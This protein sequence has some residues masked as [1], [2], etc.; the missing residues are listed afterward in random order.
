MGRIEHS[1]TSSNFTHR[2]LV[3]WQAVEVPL[4]RCKDDMRSPSRWLFLPGCAT[5][6]ASCGAKAKTALG[7]AN[8]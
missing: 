7:L 1:Q 5:E 3:F 4:L 6:M 2:Q 8:Y